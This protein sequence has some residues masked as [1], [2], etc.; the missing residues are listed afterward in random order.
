MKL[1]NWREVPEDQLNPT[2]SRQMIHGETMTVAR[3]RLRQGAIV[4]LHHHV[5]EQISMV[6]SGRLRFVIAGEE[7]I[8]SGGQTVT[9]PAN[10]PLYT[11]LRRTVYAVVIAAL[12][13]PAA[14]AADI[15]G[16]WEFAVETSQGSGSP[17]FEF[18]QN[19]EKL[20]GT[21]TGMFG[22]APLT[23][24]VKGEQVEFSFEVS[25]VDGK[26]RYKGTLEGATRMK[27]EVELGD[28][29]KGTFTAKKK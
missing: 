20:T 2:I 8:L 19:G 16:A 4:P 27:G 3:L 10:A 13:L 6:E 28:V 26:I 12:L 7:C 24:T 11:M 5:N 18:K 23:G 1:Y 25:D 15:S 17:S 21:Y 9:I 29:G 22:K 14:L